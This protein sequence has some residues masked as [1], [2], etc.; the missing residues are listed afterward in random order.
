MENLPPGAGR[1]FALAQVMMG[2]QDAKARTL[3]NEFSTAPTK[4]ANIGSGLGSFS[5]NEVAAAMGGFN[6]AANSNSQVAQMQAA[7]AA[8]ILGIIGSLAGAA[9][10]FASGG[11]AKILH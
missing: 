1:D 10:N 9:G 3:A 8:G 2:Q 11:L 4:L 6:N 5:L 7:R